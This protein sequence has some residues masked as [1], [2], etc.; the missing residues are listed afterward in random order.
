MT[1]FSY[2]F[3]ANSAWNG[4]WWANTRNRDGKCAV[5]WLITKHNYVNC[6]KKK[7]LLL[8]VLHCEFS[9]MKCS[10]CQ[11]VVPFYTERKN[12]YFCSDF[13]CIIY[14]FIVLSSQPFYHDRIT[15]SFNRL[16][17]N[18]WYDVQLRTKSSWW[19]LGRFDQTLLAYFVGGIH[20][21]TNYCADANHR[22]SWIAAQ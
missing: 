20:C 1:V 15:F 10:Q 3:H 13:L 14:W 21:R 16:H 17:R 9:L 2:K 5:G 12:T 6:E 8:L 19:R 11:G 18:N 7:K 4:T 22:V